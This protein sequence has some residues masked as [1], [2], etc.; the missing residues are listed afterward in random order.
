MQIT[1]QQCDGSPFKRTLLEKLSYS[2]GHTNT[3]LISGV[4]GLSTTIFRG[5]AVTDANH[6]LLWSC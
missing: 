1:A 2:T 4:G 6:P 3:I 5:P